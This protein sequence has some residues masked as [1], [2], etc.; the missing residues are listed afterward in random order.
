MEIL[1][2]ISM[3]KEP[4]WAIL[5]CICGFCIAVASLL[6]W[7]T[8]DCC[9]PPAMLLIC[10]IIVPLCIGIAGII[11]CNECKT[12][13][14]DEYIVRLTDISVQEFAEEYTVV[15][16]YP[17]SDVIRVKKAETEEK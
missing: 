3:Y 13:V 2:T 1:E 17:Y 14:R 7:V 5:M 9:D 16:R 15:E 6:A 8:N 11:C 4:I 10:T 12:Y